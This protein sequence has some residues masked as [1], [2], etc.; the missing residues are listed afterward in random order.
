MTVRVS[1][2][3]AAD[4]R[5]SNCLL[6]EHRSFS[7][8]QSPSMPIPHAKESLW[9]CRSMDGLRTRNGERCAG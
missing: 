3:L 6:T 1:E 9:D 4:S 2:S 7:R 8:G 5:R